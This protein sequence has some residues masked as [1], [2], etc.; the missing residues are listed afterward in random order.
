MS[1]ENLWS[2][3]V[4]NRREDVIY[5]QKYIVNRYHKKKT[6]P[7]FV[8]AINADWGF[9]KSFMLNRWKRQAEGEQHPAIF[10][11]AWQ[12]D[13]TTDPL[14]AF[15]AE[16]DTGLKKYFSNLPVGPRLNKTAINA[17]K[18]SWK[19]VLTVL[20]SAALKHAAGLS[21]AQLSTVV[22]SD[23]DEEESKSLDTQELQR[24]LKAAVEKALKSHTNI[25]ESIVEFRKKLSELIAALESS[26]GIQLPM[27]IFIDELDRCRPDYAI[28]LLEG[29]KHLFGVPG[30]YFVIATNV[31]QLGESVK[32][33]YGSGFDG[34]K[35][36]KRFF[37]LQYALREPD[38]GQF[39]KKIFM[40][41]PLPTVEN[42]IYGLERAQTLSR[43]EIVAHNPYEIFGYIFKK[44][45]DA[46]G[47]GLRDMLQISTLIES[48]LI[49]LNYRRVHPFLLVFLAV[50]FHKDQE[51]FLQV[52]RSH[53]FPSGEHLIRSGYRSDMGKIEFR[54]YDDEAQPQRK[55]VELFEIAKFYISML[56]DDAFNNHVREPEYVFPG[57]LVDRSSMQ[58][59]SGTPRLE[60][61]DYLSLVK[62][63]GGFSA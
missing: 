4:L 57:N 2:E 42:I 18:K 33:I 53:V 14:L 15:I 55:V 47:L 40:E 62:H 37:D 45:A 29:I 8:L 39:A 11:D 26:G 60:F 52:S 9:G 61:G 50:I 49:S 41:T 34:E 54:Y 63:A 44:H 31:K 7:G 43:K 46:F 59:N 28:E 24:N 32:A 51:L 22:G 48:C 16:L 3:D 35:Y 1:I 30:V 6:E 5:L 56:R 38:T 19:P 17:I 36:L 12:S 58:N 20:G 23:S 13:F 25:K 27:I 21:L 10:F